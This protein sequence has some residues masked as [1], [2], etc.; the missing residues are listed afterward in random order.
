ESVGG[1]R[2]DTR[3]SEKHIPNLLILRQIVLELL[4]IRRLREA[5]R[6]R[7][8]SLL[9]RPGRAEALGGER[10]LGGLEALSERELVSRCRGEHRGIKGLGERGGQRIPARPRAS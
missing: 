3:W 10:V 2:A 4:I 9:R 6:I 5:S 8:T 7:S 1:L